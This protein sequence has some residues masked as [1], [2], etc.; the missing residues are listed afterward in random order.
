[1]TDRNPEKSGLVTLLHPWESG[2]DDLPIWDEALSKITIRRLLKFDRLD[3][4]AV[5][6]AKE[7]IPSDDMY[8]KFIYMIELMKQYN[9]DEQKIYEDFPFKIEAIVFSSILYVANKCMIRIANLLRE[10]TQDIREWM[11]RTEKNFYKYFLPNGE[12]RLGKTEEALF[13]NYDLVSK[14]WIRRKTI[15]SFV[16]IYTGLIPQDGI[17]LF[18]KWITHAHWCG[19]ESKCYSPA[20]PSTDLEAPY[21]KPLMYWRGPVWVNTNWMIW[22]GLLKCGYRQA[23]EKI[24]YGI[25]KLVANHRFREYY[26]PFTGEGLGGRSFSWTAA[27]VIDMIKDKGIGIPPN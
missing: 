11:S 27:L 5:G 25:L 17:D 6:G 15:S 8:N 4:V 21:F 23:A 13:C 2:L 12:Q 20:L 9:Y 19:G 1:M 14:D 24:K 10:D 18:V 16:P 7:T 22:L 3:V 26:D